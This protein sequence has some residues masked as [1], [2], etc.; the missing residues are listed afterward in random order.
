MT[1]LARSLQEG[2]SLSPV[3]VL[4]PVRRLQGDGAGDAAIHF[5]RCAGAFKERQGGSRSR[6]GIG[7]SHI[8]ASQAHARRRPVAV[9]GPP[10][11]LGGQR[12]VLRDADACPVI[13]SLLG[14]GVEITT[15]ASGRP[16]RSV[17][18]GAC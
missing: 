12:Q 10:Q 17:G 2:L 4:T 5:P 11:E 15:A 8:K 14:A 18:V 9:T 16:L 3:A 7:V 13:L 1:E 6:C